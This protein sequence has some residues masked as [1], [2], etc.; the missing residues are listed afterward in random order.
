MAY[1][2]FVTVA[3]LAEAGAVVVDDGSLL[4]PLTH[5]GISAEAIAAKER[6]RSSRVDM[7]F[8]I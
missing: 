7:L 6:I 1:C 4:V 8:F 5:E 3:R 2:V